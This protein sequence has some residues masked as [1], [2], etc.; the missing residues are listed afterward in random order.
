MTC[1]KRPSTCLH[2]SFTGDSF[3]RGGGNGEDNAR[4]YRQMLAKARGYAYYRSS[5]IGAPSPQDAQKLLD[6]LFSMEDWCSSYDNL[7]AA[8]APATTTTTTTTAL[9]STS[10]TAAVAAAAD[11]CD[12]VDEVAAIVARLRELA[13]SSTEEKKAMMMDTLTSTLT[14]VIV[15]LVLLASFVPA[16]PGAVS[17]ETAAR[18]ANDLQDFQSVAVDGF[19]W[20]I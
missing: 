14:F 13:A 10:S 7:V 16:P 6:E 15:A 1:S 20:T 9:A 19:L 4:H 11:V 12:N 3:R 18:V 2:S 5:D 8:S 17:P